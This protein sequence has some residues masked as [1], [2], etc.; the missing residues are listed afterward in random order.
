MAV[1]DNDKKLAAEASTQFIKNGMTVGLGSGSTVDFM[2]QKLGILVK[3]GL[4]MKGIPTSVKTESL[5]RKYGI[6]LTDFP[7]T[8]TVD[9]A[10]DGADEIDGQMNLLKGGGGS[11]VRE[12]IVDAA[13]GKLIIIADQSKI[14]QQL[15]SFPL[16]IEVVPF[17]W[18]MTKNQIAAY[19]AEPKLRKDGNRAFISDNGNYI[20]DCSFG[21]MANPKLLHNALKSIAGVV[22]TGL[23]IGMTDKAIIG[24]NGKIEIMDGNK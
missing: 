24:R 8:A 15:G 10:I 13:A 14:V 1:G 4:D 3:D 18:E 17:G 12:K 23:F 16:P 6:P 19:G 20:L 2:L 22:E 21:E 5:A 7:E 11:L 9:L